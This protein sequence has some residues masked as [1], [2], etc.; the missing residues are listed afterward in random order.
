M[1]TVA[2]L[3]P[4][5]KII[6]TPGALQLLEQAGLDPLDLLHRH[7]TDD[8]G[9]LDPEDEAENRFSLGQGF[10]IFSS[11]PLDIGEKVWIIT[12]VDRS[13]PC[14]LLPSEY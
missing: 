7:V 4:L 3:F 13:S 8:W 6:A 11:Y 12:E 10:R 2:P 5:G 14:A 1:T 9:T